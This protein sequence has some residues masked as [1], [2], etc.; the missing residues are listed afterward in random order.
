M[1]T[2]S[3]ER[4]CRIWRGRKGVGYY[5]GRGFFERHNRMRNRY[6]LDAST[7]KSRGKTTA[8]RRNNVGTSST[9]LNG[10][11]TSRND[12]RISQRKGAILAQELSV[13]NVSNLFKLESIAVR[14]RVL[15][16]SLVSPISSPCAPTHRGAL[17]NLAWTFKVLPFQVCS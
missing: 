15:D 10:Q 14:R 16:V 5:A 6:Y 1:T 11:G 9:E 13:F 7:L 8:G 12:S 3:L 2:V 4:L 17:V